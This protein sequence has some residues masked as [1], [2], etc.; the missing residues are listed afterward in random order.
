[1]RAHHDFESATN[2]TDVTSQHPVG[3]HDLG[4]DGHFKDR[5]RIALSHAAARRLDRRDA[6]AVRRV[7]ER[8][9]DVVTQ[10]NR[11]HARGDRGGFPTG[12][13]T[14]RAAVLP[15]IVRRAVER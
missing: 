14:R 10:S 1:M 12:G 3:Q 4:V 2:I 13:P 8:S 9:A 5:A 6:T 11:T 7:A 15:G